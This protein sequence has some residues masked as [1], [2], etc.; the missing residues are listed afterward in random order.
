MVLIDGMIYLK[1]EEK[2]LKVDPPKLVGTNSTSSKKAPSLSKGVSAVSKQSEIEETKISKLMAVDS[3]TLEPIR[4]KSGEL[5][6]ANIEHVPTWKSNWK[7]Y[8][9]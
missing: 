1:F 2:E 4:M 5:M 9:K 6:T 7:E 8:Q 3:N